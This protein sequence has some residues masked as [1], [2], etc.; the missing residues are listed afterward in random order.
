MIIGDPDT[1]VRTRKATQNECHFS[2]FLSDME[3]KKVDEALEDPDWVIAMQEELNQ[4]NRQKVW[5]L[6]PRPKDKSVIGTK[7]V[8]RNKLDEDGIV[9]RNKARLVAKGY[10][11]EEGIDYDETYAPVARL[12]A[13]RMF[14]AFAAHS[15][16]KVYQMD[17]KSAFL[18]GELEEEV[19]VEQPPGFEDPN[20]VDF[21]YLLFKAL[22]GLKQAPRTWYDTLSVFLLENGFTRGVIDKT[23]FS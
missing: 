7:W 9:T 11:Q 13:I 17:V 1:G 20:L 18:N 22:Y 15:D 16:F 6:V 21:V 4:F 8:F 19:Y 10:S 14:L 5:K 2:G 23:L 12:E 3:P